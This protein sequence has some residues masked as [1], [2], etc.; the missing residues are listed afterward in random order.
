MPKRSIEKGADFLAGDHQGV[1]SNIDGR[2]FV[3]DRNVLSNPRWLDK[4]ADNSLEGW[5]AAN[6]P[7]PLR[8]Q[9]LYAR[10]PGSASRRRVVE[11]YERDALVV[12]ETPE[13]VFIPPAASQLIS[14]PTPRAT[15]YS[16]SE[17]LAFGWALGYYG[18]ACALVR[19]GRFAALSPRAIGQATDWFSVI[20]SFSIAISAAL[21]T[22]SDALAIFTTAPQT[23][24][25]GALAADLRLYDV[26]S[27]SARTTI[28]EKLV[29]PFRLGRFAPESNETQEFA[30]GP[31]L[32]SYKPVAGAKIAGMAIDLSWSYATR[33]G[34]ALSQEIEQVV[35]PTSEGQGL[36]VRPPRK[37]LDAISWRTELKL[38]NVPGQWLAYP[39]SIDFDSSQ[40]IYSAEQGGSLTL[41]DR[42]V[43]DL[44]SLPPIED[45]PAVSF[46]EWDG[47]NAGSWRFS[48]TALYPLPGSNL[49]LDVVPLVE[50]GASA[51]ALVSVA[52]WGAIRLDMR[53][54]QG[55]KLFNP[56]GSEREKILG[57]PEG[58]VYGYSFAS[59]VTGDVRDGAISIVDDD[60]VATLED[61]LTL[62]RAPLAQ[63]D[64]PYVFRLS[65]DFESFVGGSVSVLVRQYNASGSQIEEDIV[66]ETESG[67]P[68]SETEIV[69]AST[70]DGVDFYKDPTTRAMEVLVRHDGRAT[71]RN[72][73]TTMR[74]ELHEGFASPIA[75]RAGGYV[76]ILEDPENRPEE[77]EGIE[78]NAIEYYGAYD[79]P[80]QE[81]AHPKGL[82]EP[83]TPLQW[84]ALSIF[85][86]PKGL[87][88]GANALSSAF[89]GSSGELVQS[90]YPIVG[91][92]DILPPGTMSGVDFP[93]TPTSG[94]W[95][96]Y[97]AILRA[98]AN[99]AY[100]QVTGSKLGRGRLRL[101]GMQLEKG[102]VVTEF[103]GGLDQE[104][105][106]EAERYVEFII[107]CG[108][109]DS[110]NA[111]GPPA[112]LRN[113][114]E[115]SGSPKLTLVGEGLL[116]V[117]LSSGP[118]AEGPWSTPVSDPDDLVIDFVNHWVKGRVMVGVETP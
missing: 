19:N 52:Q 53:P 16:G 78:A 85:L 37:P 36:A 82:R 17:P 104:N 20:M 65:L 48:S 30:I 115:I 57:V 68:L 42:Q 47:L 33:S 34:R 15:P 117:E 59:S 118:T 95:Q 75:G 22:A 61:V 38:T 112:K 6:Y 101:M 24:E 28:E 113:L 27:T 63:R 83:V 81:G 67:T 69:F 70:L 107:D 66:Y 54:P 98:P 109:L 8:G 89:Y 40:L 21:A 9:N 84:Y 106:P 90:N 64:S 73:V 94:D 77:L 110:E 87:N 71:P 62:D 93:Q 92:S 25:A 39:D 111:S 79:E 55:N 56:T 102:V 116:G 13:D 96:R 46:Q 2:L 105:P 80:L 11:R 4:S 58:E 5:Q 51:E 99:A 43:I 108:F 91:F 100:W 97:V 103:D 1:S 7:L 14:P 18:V 114:A 23:N 10:P 29:G 86:Q 44:S 88:E 50:S 76:E 32:R 72:L 12:Q 60:S 31:L 41:V 45:E 49:S 74:V 35:V 3:V 26:V